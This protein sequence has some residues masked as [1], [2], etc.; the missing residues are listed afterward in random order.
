MLEELAAI[1]GRL[2]LFSGDKVIVLSIHFEAP[3]RSG[4]VRHGEAKLVRILVEQFTQ[5]GGLA[6]TGRSA[7]QQ[8]SG[9]LSDHVRR[10]T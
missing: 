3:G 6:G 8:Q 2:H 7:N 5:Q 9:V 1:D 10:N 4:G